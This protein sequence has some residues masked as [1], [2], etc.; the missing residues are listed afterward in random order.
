M[1]NTPTIVDIHRWIFL[2]YRSGYAF[3][4]LKQ[5]FQNW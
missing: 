2:N 5:N 4:D 3:S 1:Y